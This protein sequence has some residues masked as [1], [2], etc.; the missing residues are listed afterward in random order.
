M[1][2]RSETK[3]TGMHEI[4]LNDIWPEVIAQALGFYMVPFYNGLLWQV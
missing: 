4:L 1:S 2:Q 3:K